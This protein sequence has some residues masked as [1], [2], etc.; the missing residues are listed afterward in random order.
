MGIATLL[1]TFNVLNISLDK[2]FSLP[3][4]KILTTETVGI[5]LLRASGGGGGGGAGCTVDS[6]LTEWV[7]PVNDDIRYAFV[8][9]IYYVKDTRSKQY[10]S[11]GIQIGMLL[12]PS[13]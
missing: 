6:G 10:G 1:S 2:T 9:R 7:E 5:P 8:V 13:L 4:G 3:A 12:L 11:T